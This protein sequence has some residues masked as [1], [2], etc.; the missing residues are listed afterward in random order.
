MYLHT[1]G[2]QNENDNVNMYKRIM[3][4]LQNSGQKYQETNKKHVQTA[5]NVFLTMPLI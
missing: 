5:D 3:L 2:L 1:S 4:K